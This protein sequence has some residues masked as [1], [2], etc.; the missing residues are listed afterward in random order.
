M[1]SVIVVLFACI[2]S[3]AS[4]SRAAVFSLQH[5]FSTTSDV[6]YGFVVSMAEFTNLNLAPHDII[7]VTFTDIPD[8]LLLPGNAGAGLDAVIGWTQSGV[9]PLFDVTFTPLQYRGSFTAASFLLE[10]QL[11]VTTSCAVGPPTCTTNFYGLSQHDLPFIADDSSVT[12]QSARVDFEFVG[13]L[14]DIYGN[15][16]IEVV[17]FNAGISA[18][19]EISTWAMIL[20]GF[21]GLGMLLPTAQVTARTQQQEQ[22]YPQKHT[23]Q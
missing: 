1:R 10:T 16:N 6:S 5:P 14:S 9:V 15:L 20:L 11:Q 21:C 19:P 7:S 8:Q 23:S 22:S 2:L 13:S 12:L 18:V 17:G 4:A 3:A